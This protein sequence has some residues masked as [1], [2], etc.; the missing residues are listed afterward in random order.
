VIEVSR[1]L[2]YESRLTHSLGEKAPVDG[3]SEAETPGRQSV[4]KLETEL[5]ENSAWHTNNPAALRKR[6][7][8][9]MAF[10]DAEEILDTLHPSAGKARYALELSNLTFGLADHEGNY[11]T[12]IFDHLQLYNRSLMDGKLS[13]T[14]K[15]PAGGLVGCRTAPR[16]GNGTDLEALFLKFLAGLV[17]PDSGVVSVT[18]TMSVQLVGDGLH[19]V[20][21]LLRES[22]R[23]NILYG[24]SERQRK[25]VTD[26]EL[27]LLCQRCGMSASLIGEHYLPDWG[28]AILEPSAGVSRVLPSD[29]TRV[30]LVRALLK[31]PDVLLMNHITDMWP[32]HEHKQMAVLMRSFLDGMLLPDKAKLRPAGAI[33]RTVVWAARDSVLSSSLDDDE[34]VITLETQSVATLQTAKSIYR[35]D[36]SRPLPS[37]GAC[38]RTLPSSGSQKLRLA[39]MTP[40]QE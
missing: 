10:C 4:R 11:K 40:C 23:N 20:D 9:K 36:A 2:N 24:V 29:L 27:W 35:S 25:S 37:A 17:M 19:H 33:P 38:S 34:L 5:H 39:S 14:K 18:P 1:L 6:K 21:E 12:V 26:Q 22:L 30:V 32:A 15:V 28:K 7:P 13:L 3:S 31:R 16:A 8:H